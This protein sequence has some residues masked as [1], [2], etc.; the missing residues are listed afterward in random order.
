[1]QGWITWFAWISLLAGVV[2]ICANVTTTIVVANYPD[3]VPQG[4][5]TILIMYAYLAVFAILNM[6]VFWLIPW[7]EFVAGLLHLIQ[8]II[9]ASVL[10]VLAPRHSNSFVFTEKANLSGWNSDFV[11]FNLGMQLVSL[12]ITASSI[13]GLSGP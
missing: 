13:A 11:S 12:L 8:W 10:L 7:I 4:W 1:M 3:Y 2:N 6:Y 9:L 5:H